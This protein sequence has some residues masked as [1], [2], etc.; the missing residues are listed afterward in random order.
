MPLVF[1]PSFATP[2]AI[3]RRVPPSAVVAPR[4][5]RV[6][7]F[8]QPRRRPLAVFEQEPEAALGSGQRVVIEDETTAHEIGDR[9]AVHGRLGDR[10]GTRST[11][12]LDRGFGVGQIVHVRHEARVGLEREQLLDLGDAALVAQAR[13]HQRMETRVPQPLPGIGRLVRHGETLVSPMQLQ[14]IARRG[15]KFRLGILGIHGATVRTRD[16]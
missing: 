14:E 8:D 2:L 10:R 5:P 13:P 6:H 1:A 12:E 16:V 4:L 11:P 9:V 7:E 15:S 3:H